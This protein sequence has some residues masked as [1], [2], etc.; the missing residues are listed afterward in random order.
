[1]KTKRIIAALALFLSI[2]SIWAQQYS[3]YES[4]VSQYCN[5]ISGHYKSHH[6][7]RSLWDE[8]AV[9]GAVYGGLIRSSRDEVAELEEKLLGVNAGFKCT[10]IVWRLNSPIKFELNG[11]IDLLEAG[12]DNSEYDDDGY[13]YYAA[14][15]AI[16]PG[17]RIGSFS[18]DCGPYIGYMDLSEEDE[19]ESIVSGLDY[20][21]RIGG[22][23]RFKKFE[24]GFHYDFGLT[25]HDKTFKKNELMINFAYKFKLKKS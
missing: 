7:Y 18:I 6:H 22:T 20:G 23:F 11:Y 8:S 21:L 25:D 1:M 19:D 12:Y 9:E 16:T 5:H 14:Q 15:I 4:R 17:I 2:Q 24:L 10:Y 13:S 3:K